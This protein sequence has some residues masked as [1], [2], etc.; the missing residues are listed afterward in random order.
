MTRVDSYGIPLNGADRKKIKI[1]RCGHIFCESCWKG[2][3]HSGHGNPCICPVCRQ[4]VGKSSSKSKRRKEQRRAAR[5]ARAAS[6]NAAANATLAMG[7]EG[8]SL[9]FLENTTN[10]N[11]SGNGNG[12]SS[13]SQ[14]Y[15]SLSSPA[16][17]VDT[18]LLAGDATTSTTTDTTDNMYDHYD[19][20]NGNGLLSFWA[21]AFRPS[22]TTSRIMNRGRRSTSSTSSSPDFNSSASERRPLT[23]QYED[24]H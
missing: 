17:A 22:R 14:S 7:E 13:R 12:N 19:D 4:D 23:L 24:N 16:A 20:N 11:S 9:F 15:G 1:L 6:A 2:W 8:P 18:T 3:V 5:R 21:S 10:N